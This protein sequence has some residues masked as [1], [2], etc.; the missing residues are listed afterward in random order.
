MF[1]VQRASWVANASLSPLFA[2]ATRS[3]AIRM[4]CLRSSVSAVARGLAVVRHDRRADVLLVLEQA[5]RGRVGVGRAGDRGDD[6]L[7]G[8]DDVIRPELAER[9]PY[10]LS[11]CPHEVC[12]PKR[13][14]SIVETSVTDREETVKWG[15]AAPRPAGYSDGMT[16]SEASSWI[17][18]HGLLLIVGGLILLA[19]YRVATSL[20]PRFVTGLLQVQQAALSGGQPEA[21]LQKRASTLQ[22]VLGKLI[23]AAFLLGVVLLVLGV[24]DLFGV[25]A[26]LGLFAAALTLA[27]QAIVLDY[28]MGILILI[29][30]PYFQGDWI[31]INGAGVNVEGQVEEITLRRTTL[32]DGL[33]QLH[34]VSNGLIRVSS[35]TTRVYSLA[36]VEVQVLRPA[37]LDRAIAVA[38][39]VARELGAERGW[40]APTGEAQ[41]TTLVTGLTLDGATLRVQRRVPPGEGGAA[42]SELRRR[43]AAGLAAESVGTGR[44]DTPPLMAEAAGG[45]G[46]AADATTASGTAQAPKPDADE[47]EALAAASDTD[48]P[49]DQ[50]T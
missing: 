15:R 40:D 36:T 38:G 9:K 2:A 13:G 48:I 46:A 24:F 31:A 23:R 47:D 22:D 45:P 41:F 7:A 29:E 16:L 49:P 8:P 44:W 12:L 26:G 42:T 19:L 39:R 20:V 33:G 4:C 28:L 50:Q 1:A 25:L 14:L 32:R 21:E 10:W 43:L 5:T 27:G 18:R 37:D 34:S 6:V 11:G 30:G 35:N 3:T 17:V